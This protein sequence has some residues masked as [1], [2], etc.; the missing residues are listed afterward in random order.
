[1][2][3]RQILVRNIRII[4]RRDVKIN[5]SLSYSDIKVIKQII[6]ELGDWSA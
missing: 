4:K 3:F 6:T 2:Q 5:T 1:M